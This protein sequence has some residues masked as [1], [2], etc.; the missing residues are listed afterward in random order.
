MKRINNSRRW[1]SLYF[2]SF[3]QVDQFDVYFREYRRIPVA[4]TYKS[5]KLRSM[6]DRWRWY[7]KLSMDLRKWFVFE[8][9]RHLCVTDG[10]Q[11]IFSMAIRYTLNS[12]WVF[13]SFILSLS[14]S[15]GRID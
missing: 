9:K 4:I 14:K 13:S 8:L 10:S 6:F 3:F 1:K 12:M 7:G 2:V 5:V 11:T 15:N